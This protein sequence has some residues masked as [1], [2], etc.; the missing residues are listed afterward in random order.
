MNLNAK[1]L[2]RN[3]VVLTITVGGIVTL[4]VAQ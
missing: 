4:T 1:V 2:K 3:D